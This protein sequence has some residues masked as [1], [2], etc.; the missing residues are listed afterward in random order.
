MRYH[1]ATA[2]LAFAGAFTTRRSSTLSMPSMLPAISTAF[3]R[4]VVL[5]TLAAGALIAVVLA[6]P[7]LRAY[8]R[9]HQMQGLRRPLGM[10]VAMAF[11]P[12][13]D[14]ASE[15]FLYGALLGR[16]GERLFPGL[17]CLLSILLTGVWLPPFSWP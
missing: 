3:S 12:Q 11:Q 6:A 15:G 10:S 5:G 4:A 13:R 2:A 16:E 1:L 9:V 7:Y 17:L 14:I 8:L